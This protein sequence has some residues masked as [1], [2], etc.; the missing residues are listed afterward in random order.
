MIC[1]NFI[2]AMKRKLLNN[3]VGLSILLLAV[4]LPVYAAKSFHVHN[5]AHVCSDG[6][7]NLNVYDK[8]FVCDFIIQPCCNNQDDQV[9]Y[10]ADYCVVIKFEYRTN[11]YKSCFTSLQSRAPPAFLNNQ[12]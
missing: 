9:D 12:L 10:I 6:S 3:S 1:S 7:V 8:C 11:Y 4:L 5:H 2:A